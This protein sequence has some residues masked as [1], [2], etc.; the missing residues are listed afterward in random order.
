[1]LHRFFASCIHC[2][3]ASVCAPLTSYSHLSLAL[4]IAGEERKVRQYFKFQ[5]QKPLSVT[6]KLHFTDKSIFLEN[7]IQNITKQPLYLSLIK[8]ESAAHYQRDDLSD[9]SGCD[10]HD[11]RGRDGSQGEGGG[12]ER[13]YG[14]EA[15]L[16]PGDV[17]QYLYKLTPKSGVFDPH[18]KKMEDLGRLEMSWKTSMGEPGRLHSLVNLLQWKLPPKQLVCLTPSRVPHSVESQVPFTIEWEVENR[19]GRP[20]ELSFDT[21][22]THGL[23][24]PILPLGQCTYPLGVV[25]PGAKHTVETQYVALETG[26]E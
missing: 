9:V 25:Q 7:Q 18:E 14:V 6:T 8:F 16:G 17:R 12:A 19:S 3:K 11:A 26:R 21:S 2:H 1:M 20:M 13:I 4:G 5:V 22:M 10:S 15:H 23:M 24:G